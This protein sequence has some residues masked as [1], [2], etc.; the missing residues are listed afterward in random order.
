MAYKRIS[1][2]PVAEGGTG[3]IT[4]TNHGVLVG[5][6]TSGITQLSVGATNTVLLGST[7]GNPSFG[8]VP[9]AALTNSSVTLSNGNNITVTGSP[10]SLGGTATIAVTGTTT[11]SVQI[12]NA[13][14]S[15]TSLT[16]GTNGQVLLGATSSAPAF[17]TPT[18]GS[19]L[20]VT[21][22]ASTLSYAISAPVSIANGGTNA[23]SFVTTD[24]TVYYNGTSLVTTT[25]GTAGQ[26]LTSNGVGSA[27]TYQTLGGASITITGDTGG[28]LTSSSFT[29]TGG[30]TGLTFGGAGT[31]E[32]LTGTLIVG[33]G[34]TG[35]ATLTN[36]GVL[37]GAAASAIT[38]LAVG[39]TN[40]VLLGNTGADPS[41]GAVPNAALANS[42]ITLSNG[43]NISIS[44]S[45]VSLGGTATINVAG[46]TTNAVQIGNA[47]A[48]L[49]SL[50]VGTNGQVLL[51]ATSAAP[52]FATLTSTGSTIAY[53]T[54][55]NTL[56][57]EAS[58]SG[59]QVFTTN[60]TFTTPASTLS[61]TVFKF[62][63][64]GA[65]GG[66]GGTGATGGAGGAGG[67]GGM[68]I[69]WVSGLSA[70]QACTVTVSNTGGSGGA[71]TS[72]N[73]GT[74]GTSSVVVGS[75][76]VSAT[77]GVGGIG[78]NGTSGP[79]SAGGTASNGTL[80]ITGQIGSPYIATIASGD[81]SLNG[82][83]SAY[84][85]GGAGITAGTG[86]NGNP[87]T[88]YGASGSGAHGAS[89]TGGA[90]AP[91]LVFVEYW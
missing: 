87:G 37:V 82:A 73:G 4:L 78:V 29:F 15:L 51:G 41:F 18:A 85:A 63:V 57:I 14:G 20:A 11:N 26:V 67:A 74:G 2:M 35:R 89:S 56:N 25:T 43:N 10:L 17:V 50:T 80:N 31:T 9:N 52:A 16:V 86:T 3:Q 53:T 75:T 44:G 8:T 48:S 5:A 66:G 34:G 59:F 21:A 7:G 65:G 55:A 61:T 54:G 60:G 30:T 42:S 69:Y 32:T 72:G 68:S 39:A 38:Q 36:H 23:T 46:T 64:L 83:N 62:T 6:G 91:G 27:P 1:P 19:G 79:P 81:Y 12:G 22:N 47:S 28:G 33:N 58:P 24:G 70:S 40:T 13:G 49:T 76:T 71:N 84:G 88:G 77:G 45:P 90:G